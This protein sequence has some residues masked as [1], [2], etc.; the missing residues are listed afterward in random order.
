MSEIVSA[1]RFHIPSVLPPADFSVDQWADDLKSN[2]MRIN[3]KRELSI[4]DEG[5][6]QSKLAERSARVWQNFVPTGFISRHG[7]KAAQIIS[8]QL[9]AIKRSFEKWQGKLAGMFATVDGI[10]AKVYKER[11]D[12][13]RDRWADKTA[14]TTLRLTGDVR[15]SGA[16]TLAGWWLTADNRAIV[17]AGD[18]IIKGGPTN[19][20]RPFLDKNL[21]AGLTPQL[22]QSGVEILKN[23]LNPTLIDEQN[24]VINDFIKGLQ[25]SIYV[26]FQKDYLTDKSFCIYR[27]INDDLYLEI[28]VVKP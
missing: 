17:R 13:G 2:A 11:I 21:R 19:V 27:R 1:V 6:Y 12:E 16:V 10:E 25:Q 24:A 3:Q 22:T 23:D 8:Q 26:D 14:Q 4:P 7:R 9:K 28:Q 15:E 18:V 5:Q 20:A